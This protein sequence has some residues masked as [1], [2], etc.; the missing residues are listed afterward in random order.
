MNVGCLSV[1]L[2]RGKLATDDRADSFLF[3]LHRVSLQGYVNTP[4]IHDTHSKTELAK[5]THVNNARGLNKAAYMQARL[6]NAISTSMSTRGRRSS[7]FG[8]PFVKWFALCYQSQTV[9]CLS[10]LS[11]P[12]CL[13]VTLLYCGQTVA[14]IKMKLSTQVGLGPGHIV[15]DG[16]SAPP[17]PKGKAEPPIFSPYMLRPNGYM[18][19]DATW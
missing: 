17:P 15:L 7:I 3:F 6:Y 11:C 14:R 16:D 4:L 5:R 2:Q 19:Q 13:S 8:Q 10:V 18:D 12:V 1:T 9:V